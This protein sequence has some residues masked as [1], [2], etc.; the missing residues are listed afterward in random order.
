MSPLITAVISTPDRDR[1]S[2]SR[3][4]QISECQREIAYF[5]VAFNIHIAGDSRGLTKLVRRDQA[6][7]VVSI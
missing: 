5:G 2:R 4:I 6:N 1:Q 3:D 7:D